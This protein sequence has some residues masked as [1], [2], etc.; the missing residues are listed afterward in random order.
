MRYEFMLHVA[1]MQYVRKNADLTHYL[2]DLYYFN[3]YE[4]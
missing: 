4:V 2:K 3:K 1:M